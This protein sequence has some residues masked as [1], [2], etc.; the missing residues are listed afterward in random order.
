[1][2][3]RL[4]IGMDVFRVKYKMNTNVFIVQKSLNMCTTNTILY[5]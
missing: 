3:L 5:H 1:M 4:L 2:N